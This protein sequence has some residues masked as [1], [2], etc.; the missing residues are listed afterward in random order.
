MREIL[1]EKE[2]VASSASAKSRDEELR[3]KEGGN[4]VSFFI[5]KIQ[6]D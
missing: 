4:T 3:A 6:D 2:R 1:E 5:S